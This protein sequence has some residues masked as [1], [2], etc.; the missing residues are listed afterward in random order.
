MKIDTFPST[1]TFATTRFATVSPAP[2]FTFDAPG[3]T[4]PAGN[5]V[6]QPATDGPVTVTFNTTASTPDNGTPPTPT[7]DT[8][9]VDAP[10]NPAPTGNDP[11]VSTNRDGSNGVKP[12]APCNAV[13][14][15]DD[16]VLAAD[17]ATTG[18]GADAPT[19]TA[20]TLTITAEPTNA[21][22][23]KYPNCLRIAT[24]RPEPIGLTAFSGSTGSSSVA[25]DSAPVAARR[26]AR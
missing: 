19:P 9:N 2:K 1:P 15:V 4:D 14:V 20:G 11:R 10:D 5:T 6:A 26:R 17:S 16:A 3:R 12:A 7:T 13:A 25:A 24:P 22:A 21:V 23:N 18:W 8:S